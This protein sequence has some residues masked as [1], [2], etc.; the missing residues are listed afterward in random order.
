[1]GRDVGDARSCQFNGKW[2]AVESPADRGDIRRV[3]W[4]KDEIAICKAR[5]MKKELGRV[6]SLNGFD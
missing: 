5:M 2:Q 6:G 3:V 1:M 4:G